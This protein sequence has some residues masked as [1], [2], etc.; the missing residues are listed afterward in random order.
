MTTGAGQV[1]AWVR[2][3]EPSCIASLGRHLDPKSPLNSP[4][5]RPLF[6]APALIGNLT[7][8]PMQCL[9][10]YKSD[11]GLNSGSVIPYVI[12]VKSAVPQSSGLSHEWGEITVLVWGRFEQPATR[13]REFSGCLSMQPR[14]HRYHVPCIASLGCSLCRTGWVGWSSQASPGDSGITGRLTLPHRVPGG[15]SRQDLQ[16]LRMTW[17]TGLMKAERE[18]KS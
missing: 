8:L 7:L 18:E 11:L 15:P 4:G 14:V 10:V 2:P 16:A 1:G 9:S 6:L 3:P 13:H 17:V 12:L 5:S